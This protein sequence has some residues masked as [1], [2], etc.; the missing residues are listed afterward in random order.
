MRVETRT[1]F[2]ARDGRDFPSKAQCLAHDRET[3]GDALVG[4]TQAQ[5]DAARSF[6]DPELADAFETF[7][8]QLRR[9]RQ[10]A[11]ANGSEPAAPIHGDKPE[12]PLARESAI[13]VGPD[14]QARTESEQAAYHDHEADRNE[15][16]MDAA[17]VPELEP[18]NG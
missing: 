6:A 14:S 10:Q 9:A 17:G 15:A 4:L 13:S 16:E 5:I 3:A 2:I 7:G 1:V 12:P 18:D 11:A 8:Y